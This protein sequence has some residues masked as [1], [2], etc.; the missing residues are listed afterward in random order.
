MWV[1]YVGFVTCEHAGLEWAVIC[2]LVCFIYTWELLLFYVDFEEREFMQGHVL[3]VSGRRSTCLIAKRST[4][5][6]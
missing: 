3:S 5:L 6:I 1:E 4:C 2:G